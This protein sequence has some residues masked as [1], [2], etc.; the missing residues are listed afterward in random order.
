MLRVRDTGV[1]IAPELLPHI[2][3][4]FTQAERSLGHSQDG[5]GVGLALVQ[6][7]VELREG[8]VE[9][10]SAMGQGSEFIILLLVLHFG[11]HQPDLISTD[12]AKQSAHSLRVLVVDDNVDTADGLAIL[13]RLSG[14]QARVVYSGL[15]ALEAAD[16][17]Q[18]NVV[19][20]DIG[21]PGRDGYE[22]ARRIR[23][24]PRLKDVVLIAITGYGKETDRQRSQ[25]AGFD[26]HLVNKACRVLSDPANFGDCGGD[27]I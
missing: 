18:P 3:D 25:G 1:G 6:R 12:E 21:L 10:H 7:L 16:E 2:F 20:L 8:K 19:L 17:Y 27:V 15:S 5:L 24:Q 14:Y 4:L 22:V 23:Q 26:H 13:L 9:V 11:I